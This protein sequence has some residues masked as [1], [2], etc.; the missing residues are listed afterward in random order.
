M[1]DNIKTLDEIF[2]FRAANPPV[3]LADF[4]N[5]QKGKT[6]LLYGAGAFGRENLGLFRRYGVEP[7]AF[8]DRNAE[9]GMERMRVPVY[10]PDDAKLTSELRES[11]FVYISITLPKHI[12]S[13]IQSDL[14]QWGYKN[15]SPVQI[16]TAHQVCYDDTKEENPSADYI[17]SRK[18]SIETAY[19][20]MGDDESRETFFFFVKGHLLRDY[21]SYK[22]TDYPCQYFDAGV[23]LKKGFGGFVDC[24]AYNG[25]SLETILKYC[26]RID[27]YIAFEPILDNFRM[28]SESTNRFIDRISKG[29]LYPCGVSD[30]TGVE[31]FSIEASSSTIDENGELLPIIKMDDVLKNVPITFLK[32]D[33]EG[34]EPM[35]LRGASELIRTQ[36]PDLAISVYHSVNHFWDI[37]CMIHELVPEYKFYLRAHTPASLESVLYCTCGE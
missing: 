10:R 22:E 30:R 26:D 16:I 12:M 7:F 14:K 29:F 2:N 15:V 13:G 6:I 8:L 23:P 25:D 1:N 33:I 34:S 36:K 20:L 5:A 11:A 4:M 37:P 3:G 18:K 17:E 35:A 19:G 9:P 32:M 28:L 24:G 21:S 31:R 27:T